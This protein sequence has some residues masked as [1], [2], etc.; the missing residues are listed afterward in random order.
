MSQQLVHGDVGAVPTGKV[1]A[2][3][4][5]DPKG[6]AR[7]QRQDGGSGELFG[8]RA[9]VVNGPLCCRLVVLAIGHAEPA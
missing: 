7:L 5:G 4:V 3:G 9:D 8:D 6:A 2:Y 1:N